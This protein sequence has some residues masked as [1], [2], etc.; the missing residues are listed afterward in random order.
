MSLN[1]WSYPFYEEQR[2]LEKRATSRKKITKMSED[3]S[4]L[5]DFKPEQPESPSEERSPVQ[6]LEPRLE[7]QE[8]PP[9]HRD[10]NREGDLAEKVNYMIYL[11]EEKRDEKT[12][13]VT[14]EIILY[15]FLGIFVIF[16]VDS[17][18]KTGK[19]SR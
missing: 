5:A 1:S 18:V 7:P 11:L 4:S 8:Q 2:P 14:E 3:D 12:G 10:Y 9:E 19:Y 6:R 15:L 16:M 17:F 13:H